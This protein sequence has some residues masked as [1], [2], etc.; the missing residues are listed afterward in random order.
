MHATGAQAMGAGPCDRGPR[1]LQAPAELADATLALDR[2]CR[3]PG[4]GEW[5]AIGQVFFLAAA[6]QRVMG[7]QG[8]VPCCAQY[9]GMQDVL[10]ADSP[11]YLACHAYRP[12]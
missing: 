2:V 9:F 6:T 7:M 5:V 4:A 11:A 3:L 12:T 10:P 1:L 8:A